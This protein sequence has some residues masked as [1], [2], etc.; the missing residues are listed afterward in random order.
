MVYETIKYAVDGNPYHHAEPAPQ[1]QCFNAKI[2]RRLAEELIDAFEPP[3]RNDKYLATYRHPAAAWRG[4][5]A[6]AD[7]SS[8][9]NTFDR[10]P[11]DAE[12]VKTPGRWQSRLPIPSCGI[13]AAW[14]AAHLPSPQ[15][16]RAFNGPAWHRSASPCSSPGIYPHRLRELARSVFWSFPIAASYTRA[17]S[18]WFC[19]V[20][21]GISQARVVVLPPPGY[22]PRRRRSRPSG[23]ARCCRP[24]SCCPD[25]ARAAGQGHRRKTAPV[26]VAG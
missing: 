24:T 21:F 8:G 10:G 9:A 7:L 26:S 15:P 6:G 1:A 3:T 17:A 25:R 12:P 4:F 18:S 5:C 16:D 22:F 23:P 14:Y 11:R 19:H 20:I 13:A 2:Q